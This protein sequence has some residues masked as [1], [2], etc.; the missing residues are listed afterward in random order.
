MDGALPDGS[1]L[2]VK[3][4]LYGTTS[5]GGTY[6]NGTVFSLD[7]KTRAETVIHSFGN[8]PDGGGPTANVIDVKG[9]LYGTTA[10]GGSDG[11]GTVFSL[12]PKTG[13]ETVLYSFCGLQSCADGALPEAGLID[14]KGTLYGTT[15]IGAPTAMVRYFR[16][17]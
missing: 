2:Y 1:L 10:F 4:T 5:E 11:Y 3:G 15:G 6:G 16:W 17:T 8:A 12:D 14:V 7:R 9:T 13:T